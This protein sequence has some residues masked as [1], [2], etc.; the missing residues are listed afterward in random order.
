M[1]R[2]LLVLFVICSTLIAQ[3]RNVNASIS[4]RSNNGSINLRADNGDIGIRGKVITL[5][6]LSK[7]INTYGRIIIHHDNYLQ[8]GQSTILQ[9][10]NGDGSIYSP[11]NLR[12]TSGNINI[13]VRKGNLYIN[14]P[15]MGSKS[16]GTTSIVL[17]NHK[18]GFVWS[19]GAYKDG[20]YIYRSNNKRYALFADNNCNVG[21]GTTNPKAKLHIGG[22]NPK[23][24]FGEPSTIYK[25]GR[26]AIDMWEEKLKVTIPG[27]H[28]FLEMSKTSSG[29][30]KVKINSHSSS[31]LSIVGSTD[32]EGNV[33]VKNR[34]HV[35][36][37]VVVDG[38]DSTMGRILRLKTTTKEVSSLF[39]DTKKRNWAV[40]SHTGNF[41]I[42][43]ITGQKDFFTINTNG[44][45][46]L[47]TN[48]NPTGVP[49]NNRLFVAGNVNVKGSLD[50][51]E[52]I[53]ITKRENPFLIIDSHEKTERGIQ[54]RNRG[55]DVAKISFFTPF[56]PDLEYT[57]NNEEEE[58]EF[59][60]DQLQLQQQA[61]LKIRVGTKI[62]MKI[63]SYTGKVNIYEGLGVKGGL[64]TD[65]L[66]ADRA[67][68][69]SLNIDKDGW[70]AI[71]AAPSPGTTL[72][73]NGH[74]KINANLNV[75]G[76]TR[77][78]KAVTINSNL[79]V[80]GDT[81]VNS[82]NASG[83]KFELYKPTGI[84]IE[85]GHDNGNAPFIGSTKSNYGLNIKT[86][87]TK[88][89]HVTS[90]GNVNIYNNLNV[91]DNV[92][93]G[94]SSS[95]GHKLA[96][97]GSIRAKSVTV[98]TGW[99]DFVFEDDYK[100]MSL[101]EVEEKIE[102]NGHLPDIPSAEEVAKNGISLGEIQSKLLQKIEEL[103]LYTIQQEKKIK[104][105]NKRIQQLENQN[106]KIHELENLIQKIMKQ[107]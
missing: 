63:W 26:Y 29:N 56:N 38:E 98:D 77:L 106:K 101:E 81:N 21:L 107:K 55:R 78:S 62:P 64:N 74:S 95:H 58:E 9:E 94:S 43:D 37:N 68:L 23:I 36:S 17:Q 99:S 11:N 76:E 96:V 85:I 88:R 10:K 61:H 89:I 48:I 22:N 47:G 80:S 13:D 69:N 97:N 45:V 6:P 5:V 54:M 33:T 1:Y 91:S 66:S 59:E 20:Y 16:V 3:D 27:H 51:A 34:L 87:G 12:I 31:L 24:V 100:L 93:I 53:K 52:N 72:V 35:K 44:S 42:S 49:S 50:I 2:I 41:Y 75:F 60:T 65:R 105:Q 73:V 30:A 84:G 92:A 67:Q 104:V 19:M 46:I 70:V 79:E 7:V 28:T 40:M 90:D 4:D 86:N 39:L 18:E 14:A 57:G 83:A 71:N 82:I 102:K 32:F 25:Y 15:N 8:L 103:T